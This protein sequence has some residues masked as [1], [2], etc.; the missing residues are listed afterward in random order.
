VSGNNQVGLPSGWMQITLGEVIEPTVEQG[1]PHDKE[2]F[3]YVDISSIDNREKKI[4]GPKILPTVQAPSRAKQRLESNDVLVS[5]TRPNLNAVALVP[6]SLTGAIGSTGFHVLRANLINP[7]WLFYLVQ[8]HGFIDAMTKVVQG[9]LYPAV[10]PKD[11]NGYKIPLAPLAEQQRIIAEIEKHFTRLDAAVGALKRIR[12]NLKRY[13]V[14]VLKAACEGR[15]VP[16]EAELAKEEGRDYEPA[17][18]L[19]YRIL[20]ERRAKWE[21][22][23]LVKMKAQG[24][25]L[26]DDKW[27]A[28]YVEPAPPDTSSNTSPDLSKGWAWSGFEQLVGSE[29]N[30]MKAGPFGSA[31]KKSFYVEAGYKIYGQEQVIKGNPYYGDYYISKEHYASLSTCAVMPGDLLISLVGTTGKILI[32]PE[33]IEPG[34]INPRLLKLTL[35]NQVINA[36]FAKILL[37]SPQAKAFFKIAAHGGT[38]EILN[39]SILK[40]LPVPLPPFAEQQRIVAE[41]ER[42]ISIIEELETVVEA[43]LTRA[44]RLR[45]SI[46]KRA[47]EGKLVPQDTADEPASR[48]LER[49]KNERAARATNP[50]GQTARRKSAARRESIPPLFTESGADVI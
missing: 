25:T 48:L 23:Q 3:F 50:K 31:L 1:G 36:R 46:L 45:Q 13:R 7:V 34:I 41:V 43:N 20:K 35:N 5:M 16:T 33:D 26:K 4:I 17:D 11:V 18:R 15:L 12:A 10:R 8:T 32:L 6:D 29:P 38:M 21:A 37:E 19:L 49:I 40:S 39:L 42:H 27:K 2:E 47:F 24:K 30:A 14:S 28:K 22:D 44:E 9:A